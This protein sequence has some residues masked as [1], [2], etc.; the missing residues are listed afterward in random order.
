SRN[1]PYKGGYITDHYGRLEDIEALQIEMCQRLYMDETAPADEAPSAPRFTAMRERLY[2]V[3]ERIVAAV[4]AP[5]CRC[6]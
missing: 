3:F 4:A 2:D 1:D 6:G 5:H